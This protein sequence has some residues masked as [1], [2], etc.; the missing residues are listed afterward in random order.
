MAEPPK[1]PRDAAISLS[2]G[3]V[4][5]FATA[6]LVPSPVRDLLGKPIGNSRGSAGRCIRW[7]DAEHPLECRVD[8]I[9]WVLPA[10]HGNF[11]H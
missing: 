3:C 5:T 2:A 8:S 10:N 11:V 6:Y 7:L 1:F 9:G 4:M